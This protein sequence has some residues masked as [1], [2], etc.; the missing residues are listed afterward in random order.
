MGSNDGDND[1]K[2]L[3]KV[4]LDAYWIDKTEVTNAQYQ[5]CLDTGACTSPKT[6]ESYSRENDFI[7]ETYADFPVIHM[8]WYQARDYCRWA[9]ER[10]QPKQSGKK[11]PEDLMGTY[12]P[13]EEFNLQVRVR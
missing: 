12:I 10:R 5:L 4:Y 13:G 6:N 9:G 1:E 7:N 11:Q 2:P 3:H 8:E